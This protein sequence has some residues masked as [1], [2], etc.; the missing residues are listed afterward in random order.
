[1][2]GFEAEG[3]AAIVRGEVIK[4]PE[5][6]ATAIRIGNPASWEQAVAARDESNGMIG[7]V[8]DDEIIAAYKLLAATEGVFAEPASAASVAGLIKVKDKIEAGSKIV[9][10]L[11]GNGL[12]DPDNAI[13][14]ANTDVKKTSSDINE[15]LRA[16]NI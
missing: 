10:T 8:T 11:T 14:F 12:K 15:I 5:T 3:S 1:M 7:S 9:C 4:N 16:M 13:K 2:M 6:L